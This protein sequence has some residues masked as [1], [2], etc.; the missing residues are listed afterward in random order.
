MIRSSEFLI[1]ELASERFFTGVTECV[2]LQMRTTIKSPVTVGAGVRFPTGVTTN[3]AHQVVL[4]CE[5]FAAVWTGKRFL[6][7]MGPHMVR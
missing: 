4:P 1:T 5:T 7:R 2:A 6:A 3:M